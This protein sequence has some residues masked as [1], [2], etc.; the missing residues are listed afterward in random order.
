MLLGDENFTAVTSHRSLRA[1]Y[2]LQMQ[3]LSQMQEKLPNLYK[4]V[5]LDYYNQELFGVDEELQEAATFNQFEDL[6]SMY[7]KLE[8]DPDPIP[9]WEDEDEEDEDEDEERVPD[10]NERG[11]K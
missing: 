6:M 5:I 7:D 1:F 8:D 2:R 11:E 10:E 3:V 4:K 9:A